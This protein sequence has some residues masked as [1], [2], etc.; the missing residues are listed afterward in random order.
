MGCVYIIG[1]NES[2]KPFPR[3]DDKDAINKVA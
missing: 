1:L 2:S 3:E